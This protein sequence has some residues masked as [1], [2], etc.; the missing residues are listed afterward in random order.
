MGSI[1]K[2]FKPPRTE[3]PKPPPEPELDPTKI[4]E[5]SEEA[6]ERQRRRQR[7]RRGFRST[8]VT[9]GQGDLSRA[10]TTRTTLLGG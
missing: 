8:Q 9:G 1:I 7:R 4:E 3:K 5:E 10:T 2:L 6:K